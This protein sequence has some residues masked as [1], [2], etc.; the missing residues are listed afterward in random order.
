MKISTFV[1]IVLFPILVWGQA[2]FDKANELYQ[3]ENYEEAAQLYEEL[4]ASGKHSA[5][6]YFNL[7]NAYYKLNQIAPAIFNYERALLLEPNNKDVQT[8]LKFA[9]NMTIDEIKEAPKVGFRNWLSNFTSVYHY[10]VWAK[11]AVG[12]S[13]LCLLGF[14][15]FYFINRMVVKRIFFTLMLLFLL[16]SIVSIMLSVFEK[17]RAESYNPAII[18]SEMIALKVE[19]RSVAADVITL[20]EGT[21]VFILED[22]DDW[23]RVEL[24]D[25]TKGWL[26]K[27]T[28][29]S[30]KF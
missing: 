15:G 4:L 10:D 6:V 25:G 5:D 22:L 23:L 9:Q 28:V 30:L 19:P 14:V 26:Q 29:R 8:N 18:F 3:Q 20:H 12:F 24:A 16:S 17:N 7:G 11:I 27:E 1:L 13:V 21:K 2:S